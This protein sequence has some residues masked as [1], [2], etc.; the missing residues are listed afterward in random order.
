MDQD[1]LKKLYG[2]SAELNK[3]VDNIDETLEDIYKLQQ[4]E[5]KEESKERK[6]KDKD[7]RLA[8]Q[9]AKRKE[10]EASGKG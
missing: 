8:A 4:K 10:K 3:S 6:Q 5:Y 7:R 9:M 2:K 1:I